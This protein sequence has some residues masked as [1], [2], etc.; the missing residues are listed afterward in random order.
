MSTARK[1][2]DSRSI[3]NAKIYL[4]QEPDAEF[5]DQLQ[6][7][8]D[9]VGQGD[10]DAGTE[11]DDRFAGTLA[12]GT[13]GL[14]GAIG[15]GSN[16]MNRVVVARASWGLGAMLL[17]QGLGRPASDGVVIGFDG[18]RSSR[19]FA[20]DTAAILAGHGIPCWIF[21]TVAP[22]PLCAF[23]VRHLGAAAAVMVT[24]SHNPPADNGYKV[25][26]AS[27]GQIVP[28]QDG[29][30]AAHIAK[31]PAY[32]EMRRLTPFE[33][34]QVGLR[35]AVPPEVRD[36]WH[37]AMRRVSL[38]PGAAADAPLSIVYTA[39][40]GV[41]H[42]DV[43][44]ALRN[45]GFEGV[46]VVPEQADP[47][48]AFP[49]VA[50]P[51]PEEPGAMDRALA[52]AA[53]VGAD[54]VVAND[55]DADRLAVA[56]PLPE[57]GYRMLSG[58]EVGWLLGADALRHDPPAGWGEG[59]DRKLVVTTI[60]SST[61]LGRMAEA[62]GADY[63][64]VLTGFKWLA[65]AGDDALAAGTS[66]FV[67]GYEEALGYECGGLCRDK[68]GVHATVRFCELAASL[69][70]QGQTI[71]GA[72]D[73]LALEHGLSVGA[74]WSHRLPGQDGLA[75]IATLMA[76]LRADPPTALA[77]LP[78]TL[79]RDLKSDAVWSAD[80]KAKPLGMPPSNV[81]VYK[82]ADGTRL[83]VRPSGTE[84]KIKFYL[85]AVGRPRD[86]GAIAAVRAERQERLAAIRAD[87]EARLGLQ[88]EG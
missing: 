78:V 2:A 45:A 51:N 47:D 37:A 7:L 67:F 32:A 82:D 20:E 48:G 61:M 72:L 28:P 6:H 70:A 22:T 75:Q 74:Q 71:L 30:I 15:P 38:H 36:A 40:H 84:P 55:P 11:L 3:A 19:R 86:V 14:R 35:R 79:R 34:A 58:N 13:A 87:L 26:Q 81:L 5:R 39:M 33:A 23:A 76:T 46:A 62:M 63:A 88:S 64:E 57:G 65:K 9:R 10:L 16:R 25:Y 77:G 80:G 50:F 4:Q 73:Q 60:V 41:G 85:E 53:E 69:K 18:R 42:R 49:T 1:P 66:R 83:I 8:L 31:A 68:D 44:L 54:L 21:D 27:G 43:V 17:E 12:F 52:M 24:A 29:Q 56:V 59:P